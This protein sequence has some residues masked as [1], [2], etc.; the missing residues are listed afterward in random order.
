[1]GKLGNLMLL[2]S[3][4]GTLLLSIIAGAAFAQEQDNQ[5][6][7]VI[8]AA[9]ADPFI[10]HGV[11]IEVVPEAADPEN[12]TISFSY[13]WFINGE[14]QEDIQGPLLAGDRFSKGDSITIWIT[15]SDIFDDGP[16]YYGAKFTIPNATPSFVAQE[17]VEFSGTELR[18][19]AQASD[20]DGDSLNYS[21]KDAPE[22]MMIDPQS[23]EL[24]WSRTP[25]QTG[26]FHFEVIA[27]DPEGAQAVLPVDIGVSQSEQ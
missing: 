16:V 23:G 9:F 11:D 22:G 20:P 13:T 27:Q 4:C 18:W 14:K 21:L 24:S 2:G 26:P 7:V 12:D 3:T 15:P 6:P 19:T 10:H 17:A 5:R 1:M 25:E 8:S